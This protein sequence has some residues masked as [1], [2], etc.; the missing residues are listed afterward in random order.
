MKWVLD[1]GGRAAAG[2][3]G[4]AGDC[5]VRAV[6]IATGL[7]YQQVYDDLFALQKEHAD[8]R[9]S[10]GKRVRGS[11]SPRNGVWKE[12]TKGYLTDLGWVWT[13]TMRIGSGCQVHLRPD[14]LPSG[15]VI[16]QCSKHLATVIDGTIRDTHDPSRDG[17][18]CVYGYWTRPE[19]TS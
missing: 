5:T 1:D 9:R 2:F 7:P 11:L 13:P 8:W 15:T 3:K 12:V 17:T 6:A 19:E 10:K 4:H 16:V 18:R 14:E